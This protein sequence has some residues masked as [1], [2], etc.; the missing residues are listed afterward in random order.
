M[1]NYEANDLR[2]QRIEALHRW[3][4]SIAQR[5]RDL[6]AEYARFRAESRSLAAERH[7]LKLRF[8][9]PVRDLRAYRKRCIT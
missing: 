7:A 5:Q 4:A 9:V 3:L 8:G 2:Q 6:R 1:N